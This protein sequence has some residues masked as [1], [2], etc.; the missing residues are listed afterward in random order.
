MKGVFQRRN[1]DYDI[2]FAIPPALALLRYWGGW[3][4]E[5]LNFKDMIP[6]DAPLRSLAFKRTSGLYTGSGATHRMP[7]LLLERRW[8]HAAAASCWLAA[9]ICP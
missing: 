2:F 6:A 8:L 7:V 5:A 1:A 4:C 3:I 9:A